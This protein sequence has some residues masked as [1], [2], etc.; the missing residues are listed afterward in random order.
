MNKFMKIQQVF[1][2]QQMPV[3]YKDK[4]SYEDERNMASKF[5]RLFDDQPNDSI[6]E[7]S[8]HSMKDEELKEYFYSKPSVWPWKQH[9]RNAVKEINK[10]LID[11]GATDETVLIKYWW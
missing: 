6:V 11:N 4:F 8:F 1:N 7:W 9:P 2:C 3:H 5:L 10:W